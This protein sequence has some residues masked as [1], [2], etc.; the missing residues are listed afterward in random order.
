MFTTLRAASAATVFALALLAC[1]AADA[2]EPYQ[3]TWESLRTHTPAP[4]W[5]RDAKLGIYFH[6]GVYSVPAFGNEW[7][8]RTMFGKNNDSDRWSYDHHVQTYGD[9][10]EYPYERFVPQFTAEHF[11]ADAWVELFQQAGARFVGPVAEHHDGFAMWDSDVTPWNA[12]DRGPQ[13]DILGEIA[14]AAR[15]RDMKLVA[16]FH[17][18]RNN[19]WQK[20]PAKDEWT[21]HYSHV[22]RDFPQLL[23]DPER[24]LLYGYMPR[25][26]FLTFW[27]AKLDEVIDRYSPDIIYFDSWLDEIPEDQ[28]Q[29]FVAHYFNHAAAHD[30]QVLVAFKQEDLPIDVGVLDLEKGGMA[31]L[32]E[33]PWLTD[34]TVSYGSWCYTRDLR[35]KPTKVVLHSFIDIISKN[36]QLMLNVSPKADGT[37]PAEQQ[38]VLRE[39]GAW[40][41]KYGEAVYETRPF[42]MYGHGP[43]QTGK[44]HFGGIATDKPYTADDVRYTRRGATVYAIQLGAPQP[45]STIVLQAFAKQDDAAP[46]DVKQVKLLGSDEPIKWSQTDAGVEITAPANPPDEMAVVYRIDLNNRRASQIHER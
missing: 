25:D 36:G 7:Y 26:K 30:Q 35:I 18:A 44:G 20:D 5:F 31:E 11:D 40:L 32:A 21:G 16:T 2:A 8:P 6:W 23:D 45:G 42:V 3:P 34:D 28:R 12:A 19:L 37:I 4:E 14:A 43:T 9:P 22:K 29:Q 39:L 41:A 1:P 17:H 15:Q 10:A 13:R 38:S 24:A 27:R 46:F 33:R